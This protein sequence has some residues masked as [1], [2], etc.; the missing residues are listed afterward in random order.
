MM[1]LLLLTSFASLFARATFL[2]FSFCVLQPGNFL[3]ILAVQPG[4]FLQ[5]LVIFSV[6]SGHISDSFVKSSLH[7]LSRGE[8]A[9]GRLWTF[10]DFDPKSRRL[11]DDSWVGS[12]IV[13]F[14]IRRDIG[15]VDPPREWFETFCSVRLFEEIKQ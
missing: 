6:K 5:R 2:S 12:R 9:L 7:F 10:L 4:N 11:L 3:L 8:R 15:T 13:G 1:A 14:K